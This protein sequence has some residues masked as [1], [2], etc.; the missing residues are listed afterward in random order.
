MDEASLYAH[1]VRTPLRFK[2]AKDAGIKKKKKKTKTKKHSETPETTKP[3]EED[4]TALALSKEQSARDREVSANAQAERHTEPS[5][6]G[7]S[8]KTE[9]QLRHE[10][11]KRKRVSHAPSR[12]GADDNLD[13]RDPKVPWAIARWYRFYADL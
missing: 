3:T 8:D 11:I 13:M 10:E 9:A 7:P 1:S 2:G 6:S 4:D 5:A 12:R